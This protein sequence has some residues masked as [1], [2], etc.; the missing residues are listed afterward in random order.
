MRD[1]IKLYTA[2]VVALIAFL[3]GGANVMIGLS[4]GL[5]HFMD[6]DLLSGSN[7]EGC[8][9]YITTGMAIFTPGI[10]ALKVGVFSRT[11][12]EDSKDNPKV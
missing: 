10:A 5:Q 6:G 7:L 12:T 4:C 2:Y 3:N 1:K 11:A 9:Q 8:R